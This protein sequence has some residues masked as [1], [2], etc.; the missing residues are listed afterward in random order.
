AAGQSSLVTT[1]SDVYGLGAIL[2]AA[3]TC[4]APFAGDSVM[5]TLDQVRNSPPQPPTRLNAKL[6]R[7]LEVICLK[8]LEKD[9]RHRY[10]SAQALP[11]ALNR[12]L[13]GE[14]ITAR[15]VGPVVRLRMWARRKPALA[16][17]SAALIVASIAGVIGVTWQWRE[18]VSQRNQAQIARAEAV[19]QEQ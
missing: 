11:D 2:Y 7:E 13:R 6:P 1:A 9:P 15:P 14:P 19:R 8:C 5:N 10:A 12:G 17:L 16:G 3:L 4:R 18:A